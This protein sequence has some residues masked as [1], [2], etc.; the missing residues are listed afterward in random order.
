[1]NTHK[2]IESTLFACLAFLLLFPGV[3]TA[4]QFIHAKREIPSEC[5]IYQPLACVLWP[6]CHI[7]NA[8][9]EAATIVYGTLGPKGETRRYQYIRTY[10]DVARWDWDYQYYQEAEIQVIRMIKGDMDAKTVTYREI[11]GET[12][13]TIRGVYGVKPRV[14]GKN[15]LFF[16]TKDGYYLSPITA[17]EVDENGTIVPYWNMRI[18]NEAQALSDESLPVSLDD[19][20]A[21]IQKYL[22][23]PRGEEHEE[24]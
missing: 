24:Q 13:I 1:M 7:D 4:I 3:L 18:E 22:D 8:T 14:E 21:E 11:G 17:M 12:D 9:E 23:E 20:I 19:Y 16:L 2:K 10:G 6:V 5:K 15:Y